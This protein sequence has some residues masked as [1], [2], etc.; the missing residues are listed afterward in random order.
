LIV[1]KVKGVEVLAGAQAEVEDGDERGEGEGLKERGDGEEVREGA[2]NVN[3]LVVGLD[4]CGAQAV[5]ASGVVGV[6][7]KSGEEGQGAARVGV[8]DGWCP[9][10]AAE[11]TKA[12]PADRLGSAGC[13][14]GR[15][16]ALP[17]VSC[18]GEVCACTGGAASRGGEGFSDIP[19]GS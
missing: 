6:A 2:V 19:T 4:G 17:C 3:G 5:L 7:E 11:G 9:V 12:Q 8:T 1:K 18:S 10:S 13:A 14:D 16:P 15:H